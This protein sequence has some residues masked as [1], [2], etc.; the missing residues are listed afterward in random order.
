MS[1][2]YVTK[3]TAIAPAVQVRRTASGY[4]SG[5]RIADDVPLFDLLYLILMSRTSLPSQTHAVNAA[6]EKA[7]QDILNKE[8]IAREKVSQ[9]LAY[10]TVVAVKDKFLSDSKNV[11][12]SEAY[13][14]K[15]SAR[16]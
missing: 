16:A 5:R 3:A 14:I 6:I 12:S 13:A 11:A 7:L 4:M 10:D 15:V 2:E 9:T 8:T 1:D